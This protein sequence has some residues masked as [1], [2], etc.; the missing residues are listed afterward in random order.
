MN[1]KYIELTSAFDD[2]KVIVFPL[3]V[4]GIITVPANGQIPAHTGVHMNTGQLFHVKDSV[5]DITDAIDTLEMD[6]PNR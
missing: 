2:T 6:I 5:G 1:S 4:S 3:Y